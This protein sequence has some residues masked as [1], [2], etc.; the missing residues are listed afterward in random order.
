M[1]NGYANAQEDPQAPA[2]TDKGSI[3]GFSYQL[4]NEPRSGT[5][6]E[7]RTFFWDANDH[8]HRTNT[9]R[10]N[11][12]YSWRVNY[13]K[14]NGFK[15]LYS[16]QG[17]T[18]KITTDVSIDVTFESFG[19]SSASDGVKGYIGRD[20][21]IVMGGYNF[22]YIR[23]ASGANFS[24]YVNSIR[25]DLSNNQSHGSGSLTLGFSSDSSSENP[26]SHVGGTLTLRGFSDDYSYA[27]PD[28]SLVGVF[29]A[30]SELVAN[31]RDFSIKHL[32][33]A[34][35]D[36]TI[37]LEQDIDVLLESTQD[38]AYRDGEDGL[39]RENPSSNVW[40]ANPRINLPDNGKYGLN[41]EMLNAGGKGYA[42]INR[43]E[44]MNY[45]SELE[46]TRDEDVS[47]NEIISDS[48]WWTTNLQREINRAYLQWTRHLD[49]D[50]GK[51]EIGIGSTDD[52]TIAYYDTTENKVVLGE[53][54]L[55]DLYNHYVTGD[56]DAYSNALNNLTLAITH[57][58]A[59]QFDYNNPEGTTEGCGNEIKC[60][61]PV[62]SGSVV[63]YDYHIGNSV[64]Y[65]VTE[66]DVKHVPNATYNEDPE[67][68]FKITKDSPIGEYGVWL[69]HDFRV[70][71]KITPLDRNYTLVDNI[72]AYGFTISNGDDRIPTVSA[73][74]SGTDNFVGVDMSAHFLGAVLRADAEIDYRFES[75]ADSTATLTIDNF[76]VYVGGDWET[77]SGSIDY[78]L[79][80]NTSA[81]RTVDDKT[82]NTGFY[83]NGKYVNG[84]IQDLKNEYVGSFVAEEES[85]IK[86]YA[87][88]IK[89][90]NRD[91]D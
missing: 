20:K 46:L 1:S 37:G 81:C 58:A 48:L 21:N 60:H 18:G 33:K 70:S 90:I 15:G 29:V 52:T 7:L 62:D 19:V 9:F 4:W 8:L 3:E 22:G 69:T 14:S 89:L 63:S 31:D 80:C 76:K 68:S 72:E 26:P 91:K 49:Y 59:R 73:T 43:E 50:P 66:E 16:Y 23:F 84:T 28:S 47:A 12:S 5:A 27:I 88:I 85:S 13:Y 83:S 38:L 41:I 25:I 55:S 54:W 87:S 24:D 56:S 30:T 6:R 65:G 75:G 64:N 61:A 53:A 51:I 74:Y 78:E 32:F 86:P 79:S 10:T 39:Y 67:A 17:A 36:K 42:E 44:L 34:E 77:Q 57:E 71:G 40:Y 82:V 35:Y 11:K 45:L 2:I